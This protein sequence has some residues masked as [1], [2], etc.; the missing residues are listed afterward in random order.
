MML[1]KITGWLGVMLIVGSAAGA[2]CLPWITSRIVVNVVAVTVAMPALKWWIMYLTSM[3]QRAD[4]EV[5]KVTRKALEPPKPVRKPTIHGREQTQEQRPA[6]PTPQ[7]AS[8]EVVPSEP[9]P[10]PVS[11]PAAC[12]CWSYDTMQEV[13]AAPHAAAKVVTEQPVADAAPG[14]EPQP[15]APPRRISQTLYCAEPECGNPADCALQI[16][17]HPDKWRLVCN[18]H[19]AEWQR[20]VDLPPR[21]IS[22]GKYKKLHRK[23]KPAGQPVT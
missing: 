16:A 22:I 7:V 15:E 12:S 10:L 17:G 20:V 4:A 6:A 1:K 21:R 3:V 9:P 11:S 5:R 13:I 23:P 8:A 2:A 18:E 19:A 14:V